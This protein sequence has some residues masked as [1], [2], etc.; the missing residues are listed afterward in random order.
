M[1]APAGESELY[2]FDELIE[3]RKTLAI[4]Y[5]YASKKGVSEDALPMWVA[6]MDFRSPPAV[7]EAIA[8]RARHGIYG[9][10]DVTD[11]Y[12]AAVQ[13]W[14]RTRYAYEV[15]TCNIVT[16]PGV[17]FGLYTA[18]AALTKEG[19]SV[20]V[21][22]P[23]YYPFSHAVNDL[24]RKLVNNP[25]VYSDGRYSIDFDDFERQVVE[26]Q[27]RLYILCN[28]H[29]PVGRVWTRDELLK[30]GEICMKHDVFVV[31]DEIHSD[32]VHAGHRHIVFASLSAELAARTITCT[33]PSKTF[34]L[35][36]LQISNMFITNEEIR[37]KFLASMRKSGYSQPNLMGLIACQAAYEG[38]ASWLD[39]LLTYLKGNIRF[40][41]ESLLKDFPGVR[42]V[43]PEGTYLLW[44]DFSAL[45]LTD[46]QLRQKIEKQCGVW[47]D[48]GKMFGT[49][50]AGFQRINIACPRAILKEAF[51]RLK[52]GLYE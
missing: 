27:V 19:E 6:D 33:A 35:A 12:L 2:N 13:M 38:G 50:G 31:S 47:L 17:V 29:N 32:F 48:H 44:L 15:D 1:T 20:L 18:V 16:S 21:S 40:V 36:G 30:I 43:E 3:R 45:G 37:K 46:E 26:N 49:E 39:S 14:Y 8:E 22:P 28:P 34:N 23:V 7:N 24:G 25:L 52:R 11:E 42:L 51:I 41:K 10:S 9:Y 4:K 5:D